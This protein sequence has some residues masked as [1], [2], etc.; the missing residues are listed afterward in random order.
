M[1]YIHSHSSK[2][3]DMQGL[4]LQEVD[5]VSVLRLMCLLSITQV[6]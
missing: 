4:M 3:V 1:L 5:I 6:S 2:L